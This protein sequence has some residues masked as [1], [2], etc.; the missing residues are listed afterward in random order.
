MLMTPNISLG[1]TG[2]EVEEKG[3]SVESAKDLINALLGTF[4]T[5]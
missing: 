3:T 5:R 4:Y 2:E 1:M